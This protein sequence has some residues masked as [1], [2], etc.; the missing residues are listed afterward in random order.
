MN[1]DGKKLEAALIRLKTDK[2]ALADIYDLIGGAVYFTAYGILNDHGDA[3]DALQNTM[4]S[5]IDAAGA[6]RGDGKAAPFI[7]SICKNQSL[8]ILRKR[9]D[10]SALEESSAVSEDNAAERLTMIDALSLL[11]ETDRGIV[12]DHALCGMKF[13][14]IAEKTGLGA[15]AAQKRYVRALQILK[16]YYK[17]R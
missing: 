4:L 12:I 15:E 13:K 11:S 8:M 9:K 7:L 17:E 1:R 10:L 14:D 5:L 3:E 2:N 16:K 6:Y